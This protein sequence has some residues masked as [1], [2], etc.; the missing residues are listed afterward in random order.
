MFVC[1]HACMYVCMDA[2]MHGWMYVCMY[3]CTYAFIILN[4]EFSELWDVHRYPHSC[5]HG[6][7]ASDLLARVG[8]WH[9]YQFVHCHVEKP[10]CNCSTAVNRRHTW[11]EE[12]CGSG[13]SVVS[14]PI[15]SAQLWPIPEAGTAETWRR[16][17]VGFFGLWWSMADTLTRAMVIH[18][19]HPLVMTSSPLKM[20]IESSWVSR[21]AWWFS[22]SLCKRLPVGKQILTDWWRSPSS[23]K[24]KK[25]GDIKAM[26]KEPYLE[27]SWVKMTNPK[28]EWFQIF[29]TIKR[30]CCVLFRMDGLN[31]NND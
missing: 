13:C 12:W 25:L 7:N 10:R 3:L 15:L 9:L 18:P 29:K 11:L 27:P 23:T 24:I 1:M 14:F 30:T 21:R 17:L 20:A 26:Q 28:S 2:C 5:A 8:H 31:T 19:W 4:A 6:C 16:E 22:S